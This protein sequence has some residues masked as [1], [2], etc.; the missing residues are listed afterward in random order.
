[1]Q[2]AGGAA[3]K[4]R[5]RS[6][7]ANYRCRGE[8]LLKEWAFA[9]GGLACYNGRLTLLQGATGD[10][11][12]ADG[13]ATWSWRPCYERPP[14]LL[15][16]H[17]GVAASGLRCCSHGTAALLRVAAGVAPMARQRCCEWP[18]ALLPWHGRVATKVHWPGYNPASVLLQAPNILILQ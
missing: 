4:P 9:N 7:K 12:R 1:L 11:T 3:I 8:R 2:G 15:T 10:A 14:A 6:C 17:D 13:L 18:P 16:W 5:H